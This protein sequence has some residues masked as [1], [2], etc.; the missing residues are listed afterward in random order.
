MKII[1]LL[2]ATIS[3]TAQT[4][5]Q[6]EIDKLTK[7]VP[8]QKFSKYVDGNGNEYKLGDTLTIGRGSNNG[9]YSH[10]FGTVLLQQQ[11][12]SP[13]HM[14]RKVIV[15]KMKVTGTKR[16]GFKLHVTTRISGNFTYFFWLKDAVSS[17]EIEGS[18]YSSDQ[19]LAELK[20]CKDKLDLGLITQEE[21]N[22]KRMELAKF[23]K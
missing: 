10:V 15:M 12:L 23:I 4:I 20:R 17:G 8:F 9:N 21:F 1:I 13:S 11:P 18:G 19:A 6:V 14:G 16:A 22:A 2:L 7:G 5:T 3:M